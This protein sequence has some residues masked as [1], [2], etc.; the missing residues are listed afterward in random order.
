MDSQSSRFVSPRDILYEDIHENRP[1]FLE[2]LLLQHITE[3]I[4]YE[5]HL[6][7]CI[8]Q[9]NEAEEVEMTIGKYREAI[10]FADTHKSRTEINKLLSRGCNMSLE[11]MLYHEAKKM[12]INV[13]DFKAR[14]RSGLLQK[15]IGLQ[16]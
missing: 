2:Q 6:L 5:K 15:S 9:F 14:L 11:E 1:Y 7:D 16:K 13:V 10:A 3:A 12:P 4:A 8:D